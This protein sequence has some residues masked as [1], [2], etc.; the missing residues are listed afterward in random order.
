MQTTMQAP[1]R[2]NHHTRE[3]SLEV[4]DGVPTTTAQV[5]AVDPGRANAAALEAVFPD[6]P[7]VP[8]W[9][10]FLDLDDP[11]LNGDS[12]FLPFEELLHDTSL[13]NPISGGDLP[14]DDL[15][16]DTGLD[17]SGEGLRDAQQSLVLTQPPALQVNQQ[18]VSETPLTQQWDERSLNALFD[19]LF[20]PIE[21]VAFEGSV[22]PQSPVPQPTHHLSQDMALMS[23]NHGSKWISRGFDRV[24]PP[25]V[26]AT[27]PFLL[28]AFDSRLY[29]SC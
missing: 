28:K 29:D 23:E 24:S 20:G 22:I 2:G 26:P 12:L 16:L 9:D 13:D 15:P 10:G 18:V 19:E 11:I 27:Q 25:H 14:L 3:E 6:L 8:R 17:D 4:T 5:T 21:R 7:G 1:D